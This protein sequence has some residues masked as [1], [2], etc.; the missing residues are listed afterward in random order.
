MLH[1]LYC[2]LNNI[3]TNSVRMRNAQKILVVIPGCKRLF[4]NLDVDGREVLKWMLR[5]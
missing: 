3:A 2:T 1:N 4:R 5:K